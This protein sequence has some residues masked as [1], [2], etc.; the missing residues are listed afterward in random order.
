MLVAGVDVG[1]TA[2]KAIILDENRKIVGRG[3]TNTGANVVKAAERAFKNALEEGKFEE[4]E[5]TF[6]V[7]TGYGRYKVPFGNTQVTEIGCHSRGAHFLFP[8]T[9]TILDIG[10]QDTKAIKVG[11]DGDVKDFCMNDKCAAGTG[12]FLE[13][14]AGVLGLELGEIGDVSQMSESPIRITNVCTVFV[15][16]EIMSHLSKGRKVEDI[17]R[18]VHNAIAGRSIALMRRISLEDE[19]TFTGGVSRNKGMVKAI[20]EKLGMKLN[21]CSDSQFIGAIGAALFAF[22]KVEHENN[23]HSRH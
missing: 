12:R 22:E 11:A 1:S 18:G 4:W 3:L 13:A 10:G 14:A 16:A 20:E 9:R 8:N 17:L 21:V 2:T 19:I 23:T 5:V 6:I 7:G 15:E